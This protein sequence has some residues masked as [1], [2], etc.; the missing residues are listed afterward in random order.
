MVGDGVNDA[1]AL[2]QADLGVAIGA[3][4]DV[5]IETA[6]L[7]LMR[8]DPL[9]V[10]IALR[11]GRGTLR[12]MRQ[13][14]WWAVG[15]NVI[16][17]PIAAGVF[18]PLFGLVLRPE[19]AAL[20]I[21]DLTGD[22]LDA[23]ERTGLSRFPV[24]DGDLDEIVGVVH[25]KDVLG[26]EPSARRSTPLQEL[27][28]PVAMVPES[29]ELGDLLVQLQDESGQF[30]VVLDEYGSTAGIITLEDMVEEIVGD[31]SDEYDVAASEPLVRRWQG[32][33]LLSGRLHP[34]EA[35]EA[36]RRRGLP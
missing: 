11:I 8:S 34:D 13:N 31:I 28:R 18:K 20:S 30:A 6:D 26:I 14:L 22:L 32:A 2:A 23:S 12:K 27:L 24:T 29:R 3:G 19:I 10:P 25:V 16:A 9:D 15:Y 4:T 21:D 17:L 35:P 33:H 1:P 7:V 36:A 5:A